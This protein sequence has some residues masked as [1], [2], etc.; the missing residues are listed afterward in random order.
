MLGTDRD[1]SA[2]LAC[3]GVAGGA[4]A[5]IVDPATVK[6]IASTRARP[7]DPRIIPPRQRWSRVPADAERRRVASPGEHRPRQPGHREAPRERPRSATAARAMSRRPLPAGSVPMPMSR[8][9][10]VRRSFHRPDALPGPVGRPHADGVEELLCA[11]RGVY[12]GPRHRQRSVG[13]RRPTMTLGQRTTPHEHSD[14]RPAVLTLGLTGL[15]RIGPS[16]SCWAG[17]A[18]DPGGVRVR[19]GAM[20]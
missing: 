12:P 15:P 4:A 11:A 3:D 1:A 2:A 13:S 8:S 16:S 5:A 18:A 9:F 19:R 10:S 7:I 14:N 6:L 20:G 17:S